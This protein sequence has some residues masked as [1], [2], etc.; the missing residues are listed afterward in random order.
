MFTKTRLIYY[1]SGVRHVSVS[2]DALLTTLNMAEA[3]MRGCAAGI[4]IS[5]AYSMAVE[6]SNQLNQFSGHLSS[7]ENCPNTS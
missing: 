7:E 5:N 2:S 6:A 4:Y 1:H 3:H